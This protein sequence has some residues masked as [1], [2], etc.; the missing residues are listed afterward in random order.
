M[1]L[2]NIHKIIKRNQFKNAKF[3]NYFVGFFSIWNAFIIPVILGVGISYLFQFQGKLNEIPNYY[4]AFYV[5]IFIIHIIISFSF[6]YLDRREDTSFHL[7]SVI[8]EY[9]DLAN[10]FN[11]LT[12]RSL[13][14]IELHQ[15][16]KAVIHFTTLLI[17]DKLSIMAEKAQSQNLTHENVTTDTRAFFKTV[18][19]F[20]SSK[21]EVLFGYKSESKFNIALYLYDSSSDLLTVKARLCD[22]RLQKRNRSWKSGFGHVGLTHLHKEIKICPD[23]TKSSELKSDD[24]NDNINYRS[25]LSVPIMSPDKTPADECIGVLVL[26]SADANQ[27]KIDRDGDFLLTFSYLLTIYV[28]SMVKI[29]T[30]EAIEEQPDEPE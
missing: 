7:E 24:D 9:N 15:T 16:Q 22:D 14:Q 13:N 21:R 19:G 29:Y 6:L 4:I 30:H 17:K 8:N 25:F 26:T 12:T 5:L 28:D 2:D 11:N 27:F 18:L 1:E 10:K 23:I 20:L 3:S